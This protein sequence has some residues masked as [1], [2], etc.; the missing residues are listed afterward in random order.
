MPVG[1]VSFVGNLAPH[2]KRLGVESAFEN[3]AHFAEAFSEKGLNTCLSS[4]F[5]AGFFLSHKS[6]R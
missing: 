4:A 5:D 3:G 1:I 2:F 6:S